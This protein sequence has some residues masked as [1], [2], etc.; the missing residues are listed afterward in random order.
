MAASGMDVLQTCIDGTANDIS[1]A[2]TPGYKKDTY[3][4]KSFPEMLLIEKGGPQNKNPLLPQHTR[5]IGTTSIGARLAEISTDFTTGSVQETGNKTD[6]FLRG[7]GFFAVN[8][9]AQGDPGRIC[10]TRNG[11]FKIDE[12]G[13]LAT[14]GGYRVL[15]ENGEILLGNSELK[16]DVT[17]DG[18]VMVDGVRVEK[19]QLAEFSN[20]NNLYKE[21]DDL[22]VDREGAAETASNTTVKQGFLE[23]S[24]VNPVDEMVNL[25]TVT[26]AYE[27]NQRLIQSQD[28]MLSKAV[29]QVGSLR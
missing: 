28:E 21:A 5:K 17:S 6:I 24:N 12:N 26:R 9:P 15:G 19:L 27:A 13:Y 3:L 4:I 10:Y 11:A 25:I 8:A 7:P 20:L 16:F 29:N 1:N 22:F 23:G 14:A 18:S 2:T